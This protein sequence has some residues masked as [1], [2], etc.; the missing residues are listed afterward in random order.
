M[1]DDLRLKLDFVDHRK[2]KKMVL[3][4]GEKSVRCLLRLWAY[5]ARHRQ[6]GIL[7]D[8]TESDIAVEAG[9]DGDVGE[10]ISGLKD[11][12]Y[13]KPHRKN[14]Y[15][16]HDWDV[17]QPWVYHAPE[18]SEKAKK[19]ATTRHSKKDNDL[20]VTLSTTESCGLHDDHHAPSPS[21]LPSPSPKPE[22]E[23]GVISKI[24]KTIDPN[25]PN[26]PVENFKGWWTDH[27]GRIDTKL[28]DYCD[29]WYLTEGGFSWAKRFGQDM[30]AVIAAKPN[31]YTKYLS[32]VDGWTPFI[33]TWLT[34]EK[35]KARGRPLSDSEYDA[36]KRRNRSSGGGMTSISEIT[37]KV[38]RGSDE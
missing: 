20:R 31:H 2:T 30:G 25:K 29:Q 4:L 15:K 21:P 8:M 11:A 38:T 26:D 17:H 14:T 32:D 1:P 10:F 7:V 5:A 23:E 9:W 24:V 36:M 12:K 19:A 37:N 27:T 28:I 18:R 34:N 13:L 3:T 33:R 6:K 22:E 35:K 16:L